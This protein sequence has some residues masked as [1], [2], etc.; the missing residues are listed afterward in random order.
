MSEAKFARRFRPNVQLAEI[1]F[2]RHRPWRVRLRIW[3][4]G[5]RGR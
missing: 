5:I 3:W 1:C 4:E 2:V